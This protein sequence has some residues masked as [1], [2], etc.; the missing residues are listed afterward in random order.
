MRAFDIVGFG[1][2]NLDEL[3]RVERILDDDE[4]EVVFAGAYPGGSAANTIY[5]LAQLGLR[6]GFLGAVGDDDAGRTLLESFRSVGVDTSGIVIKPKAKTGRVLGFIDAQGRRTL[7]IEPGANSL[8][9]KADVDF[10]YVARARWVH[11]SSFVGE[12]QWAIQCE[13][14]RALSP[15]T[16]VSFAPGRLLVRRGLRTLFPVL[17][18]T[19][20]LFLNRREL[21]LLVHTDELEIGTQSLLK[22]GP[23]I[24]AVTLGA[25]GSYVTDGK[26]TY[27]V[28]APRV[29]KVIDTTGAGDAFAAGFL[30]GLFE[31]RGL[32]ECAELGAQL[33]KLAVGQLGGRLKAASSRL[34]QYP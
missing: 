2:L 14:V 11:L 9:R 4:G 18:R 12:E 8:L 29:R 21:K 34:R 23:Q 27:R 13:L 1:A 28:E 15:K 24:V 30:Y 6:A 32:R 31:E 20:V 5:A 3:Y 7:Y 16:L 19:R 33:A 25:E 26:H 17:K 10:S 22:A